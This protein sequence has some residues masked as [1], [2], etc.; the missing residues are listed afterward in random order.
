MMTN[1]N[2]TVIYTGVTDNLQN[3]IH[4]HKEKIKKSFTSR[5]SVNKLVFYESFDKIF[6]AIAAE[7]RIK[8]GTRAKKI[9]LIEAMN[10]FWQDF[11]DNLK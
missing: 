5:Y 10:P 6:D 7:K 9:E 4:Q 1:K 8:A 2:H 3:R 11:S